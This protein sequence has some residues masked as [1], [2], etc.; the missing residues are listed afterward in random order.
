M[1]VVPSALLLHRGGMRNIRLVLWRIVLGPI[2]AVR[3]LSDSGFAGSP[4]RALNLPTRILLGMLAVTTPG[5]F[6][7]AWL[8][9]SAPGLRPS[10]AVGVLC[11]VAVSGVIM[12]LASV[13]VILLVVSRDE[14]NR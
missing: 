3:T 5:S 13:G 14:K 12:Y 7:A 11:A 9:F 4:R 10:G 1:T 6:V 8:A 2:F